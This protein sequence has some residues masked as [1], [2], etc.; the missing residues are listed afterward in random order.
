MN[1]RTSR[2]DWP[3]LWHGQG[4][5][6]PVSQRRP[7]QSFHVSKRV[8]CFLTAKTGKHCA[9]H[10]KRP[11][12]RPCLVME[13]TLTRHLIV[14]D[15]LHHQLWILDTVNDTQQRPRQAQQLT[16]AV[17]AEVDEIVG[18]AD[19]LGKDKAT[20]DLA[21]LGAEQEKQ[22]WGEGCQRAALAAEAVAAKLWCI[23]QR[24]GDIS[25]SRTSKVSL[26]FSSLA[27]GTASLTTLLR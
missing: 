26:F 6:P 22:S 23:L 3:F 4:S 7:S 13:Q 17:E 25:K 2:R 14:V 24:A 20:P 18:K 19:D 9:D 11:P 21:M 15:C 8:S 1:Q 27:K 12:G 16:E 5:T 10:R